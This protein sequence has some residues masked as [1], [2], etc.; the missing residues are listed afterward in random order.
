MVG[1]GQV[2][3]NRH[4]PRHQQGGLRRGGFCDP[5]L[6]LIDARGESG[7]EYTVFS[8]SQAAVARVRHTD[9]GSAQA[10]ASAAVDYSY[11]I[12]AR[13]NSISLRWTPAHQG[14]DGNEQADAWARRAA[15]RREGRAS[16]DYLREA[17]LAHLTRIST[18][19][20][21]A[22][23]GRWIREHVGR[24]HRYCTPPGGKMRKELGKVKKERAARFYQLLSGH[25][26]MA[27]TFGA[28]ARPPATGAGGADQESGRRATT[29]SSGADAGL[30]RSAAYGR[31]S[32]ETAAPG[33]PRCAS[34]SET[35]AQR[36]QF[37]GS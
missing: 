34:S 8:D 11:Q 12:S 3:R 9:C 22:D 6:R 24:K 4:L 31:A 15:E 19:R 1:G 32:R 23:R 21:V 7:R 33:P 10:L 14:V 20:R 16:P 35:R 37:W 28:S 13:G 26:A 27:P 30:Q 29:S 2:E 36:R 5:A 18:E 17:S 25:A